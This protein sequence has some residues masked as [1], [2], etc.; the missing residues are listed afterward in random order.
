LSS[1]AV[2]A[3]EEAGFSATGGSAGGGEKT[4]SEFD[5]LS[6]EV[7]CSETKEEG[8]FKRNSHCYYVAGMARLGM[9][10]FEYSGYDAAGKTRKGLIEAL[11]KKQAREKLSAG[12]ILAETVTP[13]QS[14]AG[15]NIMFRNPFSRSRRAVFYG[16][17]ASLLRAGLPLSSALDVMIRSPDLA[18]TKTIMAGIRDKIKEG[19][20]LAEA[21]SAGGRGIHPAETAF[22]TAG[23]KSGELEWALKNLAAFMNEETKLRERVVTA[24]IYPAIIIAL[25]LAIAVGLLGFA[26]PRLTQVMSEQMNVTLPLITRFMIALGKIFAK[27]GPALLVVIGALIFFAWRAV[28]RK[29]E[30]QIALDRKLFVLPLIGRC[31]ATLSAL[32]FAR[33]LALLLHGGVPLVECINLAGQSTGSRAVD[34]QCKREA[35]AVRN[36]SSLSGAVARIYPLGPLLAGIIEIGESTGALEEVL[37]SAEERYQNQWEQQLARI[38][39]WFE[40]V[41]ILAVGLFVLLVVVSILLPILMLNRQLM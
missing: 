30:Y 17:M 12:G 28:S 40:P 33:T 36:G 10:T 37:K 27:F 9:K 14:A 26:M 8:F 1:I 2:S 19:G 39:A 5:A 38:M 29:V 22:I 16:E 41:L 15:E 4:R 35:E 20:S 13:A 32:R 21:V 7:R 18:A 23:E 11:D 34:S 3:T 6:S 31:Y 25:A 24:L